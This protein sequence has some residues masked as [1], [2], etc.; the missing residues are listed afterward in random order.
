ML[1]RSYQPSDF[2]TLHQID[3]A[4]FPPAVSYS[5]KELAGF[6]DDKESKT[7][8]AEQDGRI[9]GFLVADRQ[10]HRAGHIITLDVLD[11]W[12]RLGVGTLLMDAAEDWARQQG[13]QL[14]YLET[15]EQNVA[16]QQFYARREYEKYR[17]VERYYGNG[18]A[19]WVMVKW[20]NEQS[21]K[22]A[23]NSGP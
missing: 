22:E 12:R 1:L 2:L 10:T 15:S 4:C 14:I 18:D 5:Q 7:W 9:I 3:Q 13:L 17:I 8:V 16:A 21:Q 6:I 19:A 11:E 20:L 23:Q